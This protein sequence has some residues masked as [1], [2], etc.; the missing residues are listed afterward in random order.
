M[1][2]IVINRKKVNKRSGYKQRYRKRMRSGVASDRGAKIF[3]G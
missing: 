1:L 3:T 2:Y